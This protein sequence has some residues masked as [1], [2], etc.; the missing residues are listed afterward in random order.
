MEL[1]RSYRDCCGN[2][3][4]Q[5]GNIKRLSLGLG[6][7]WE[8]PST[9][10]DAAMEK[11]SGLSPHL[12]IGLLFGTVNHLLLAVIKSLRRIIIS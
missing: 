8:I 5:K 3:M 12:I 1:F 6:A 7:V 4:V 11:C 2:R 9:I 10:P